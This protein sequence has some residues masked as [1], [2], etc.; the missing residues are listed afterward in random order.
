MESVKIFQIKFLCRKKNRSKPCMLTIFKQKGCHFPQTWSA[1][2]SS[3]L[4]VYWTAPGVLKGGKC[5]SGESC[6]VIGPFEGSGEGSGKLLISLALK[7]QKSIPWLLFFRNGD[8]ST[9]QSSVLTTKLL[10]LTTQSFSLEGYSYACIQHWACHWDSTNDR[11]LWHQYFYSTT[12]FNC[13]VRTNAI[14]DGTLSS[15][16]LLSHSTHS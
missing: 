14:L 10:V 7:V 6:I 3:G 8:N 15:W 4:S 12:K 1:V 2:L 11:H 16:H 9:W 13:A 5:L